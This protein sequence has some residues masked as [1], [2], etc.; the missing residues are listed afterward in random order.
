M[1]ILFLRC[2]LR[3]ERLDWFTLKKADSVLNVSSCADMQI[4]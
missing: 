2:I 4:S 1:P 3:E